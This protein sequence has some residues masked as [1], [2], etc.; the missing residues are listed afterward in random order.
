MKLHN[1]IRKME[2]KQ[3]EKR[4]QLHARETFNKNPHQH[5]KELLGPKAAQGKPGFSREVAN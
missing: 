4:S 2:I 3:K 5:A 1:K